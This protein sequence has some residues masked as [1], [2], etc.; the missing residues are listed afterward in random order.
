MLHQIPLLGALQRHLPCRLQVA[1][2]EATFPV[3][4]K[5]FSTK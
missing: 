3:M 5:S 4:G 1:M 2:G